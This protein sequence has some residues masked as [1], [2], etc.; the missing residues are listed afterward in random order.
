MAV[1]TRTAKYLDLA[2]RLRD[3]VRTGRLKPGDRLPSFVELR[4]EHSISRG[5]VEKVHAVLEREGLIVREQGRGVFVAPPAP[6]EPLLFSRSTGVIGFVG[7]GFSETAHSLFWSQILNGIRRQAAQERR[8]LL[9]LTETSDP[10]VWNRIDGLLLSVNEEEIRPVLRSVPDDL[11]CVSLLTEV[12]ELSSV[13]ADD[14]QGAREATQYLLSLGH[15]RI[16]HLVSGFN[17]LVEQ[18]LNGYRDAL[19]EAGIVPSLHGVRQMRPR[20]SSDSKSEF[21]EQGRRSVRE[22]LGTNWNEF[23]YTALLVQND[24]AAIGAI[25]AFREAG[26]RVPGDVSVVGFDGSELYDF[27]IPRLTTVKVPVQEIGAAAVEMLLGRIGGD[28]TEVEKRKLPTFLRHGDSAAPPPA[29]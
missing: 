11:P 22:W 27:F 18:R 3:D 28:T 7:G 25:E 10:D 5:T 21:V 19:H 23:G 1:E 8:Q 9:L 15:T 20:Q 16:G 2:H 12:E 6:A 13:T 29:G 14:Y 4:S 24:N 17:H 26:L